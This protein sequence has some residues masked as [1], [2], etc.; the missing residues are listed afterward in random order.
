[1]THNITIHGQEHASEMMLSTCNYSKKST[2]LAKSWYVQKGIHVLPW[3]SMTLNLNPIKNLLHTLEEKIK[4]NN[5][6]NLEIV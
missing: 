4:G 6:S 1:M 3:S 2:K 5:S